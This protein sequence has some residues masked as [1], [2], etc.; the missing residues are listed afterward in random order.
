METRKGIIWKFVGALSLILLS[1]FIINFYVLEK[2]DKYIYSD[3]SKLP[4]KKAVLILGA[5]VHGD[6]LSL[7]LRDR[8][9]S[10]SKIYLSGRVDKILLSGDHGQKK[11]DEVNGMRKY[12][13][14]NYGKNISEENIFMDHAGFDTYD[15]VYRAKE[16]FGV[17][18]VIIVT[19]KFHINRAVFLARSVGID[20]VGFAVDEEKYILP[21]KIQWNIRE[22]LSRIKAFVDIKLHMKPKYLGEKIPISGDGRKSWD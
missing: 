17:D 6:K 11:Y 12:I 21:L 1:V 3:L 20:A 19:Q 22:S 13:I 10:G 9:I 16:I 14:S 2:S 5:Q 7:V 18:S 15:S 8:V 4:K